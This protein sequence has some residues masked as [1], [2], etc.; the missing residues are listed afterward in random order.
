[1]VVTDGMPSLL[2]PGEAA[3]VDSPSVALPPE[4][5]TAESVPTAP[6]PLPAVLEPSSAPTTTSDGSP[7]PTPAPGTMLAPAPAAAPAVPAPK[8]PA[9]TNAPVAVDDLPPAF[10]DTAMTRKDKTVSIHVLAN[11]DIVGGGI[12][13]ATL[14]VAAEPVHGTVVVAGEN[15]LYEPTAGFTGTD[16][17]TYQVC[18]TG[19]VCDT[20]RVT[21]VVN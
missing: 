15:L 9:P 18:S 20:A 8:T 14:A 4:T 3:G 13:I 2:I 19:G 7:G 10:D 6:A 5:V 17:M 16:T 21:V 12:D 1:M 11:D